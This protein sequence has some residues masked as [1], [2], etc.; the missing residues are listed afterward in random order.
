MLKTS[1]LSSSSSP[2]SLS[3]DVSTVR[4]QPLYVV[5]L[6]PYDDSRFLCESVATRQ[7]FIVSAAKDTNAARTLFKSQAVNILLVDPSCRTEQGH[8][9]IE[10]VKQLHP[11][12][13]IVLV[14]PENGY[15]APKDILRSGVADHLTKPIDPVLL[16][17]VLERTRKQFYAAM[18]NRRSREQALSSREVGLLVGESNALQ[19]NLLK[20]ACHIKREPIKRSRKLVPEEGQKKLKNI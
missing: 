4:F 18:R 15:I 10:E 5:V 12:T 3:G 14:I 7:S 13:E 20:K 16:T 6:D 1:G 17:N 2:L 11:D 8:T 9:F 19:K